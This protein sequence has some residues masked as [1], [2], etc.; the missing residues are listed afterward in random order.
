MAGLAEEFRSVAA[1]LRRKAELAADPGQRAGYDDEART[2]RALAEGLAALDLSPLV[3]AL[4]RRPA[5]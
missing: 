4:E 1:E 2:W 3:S 5:Q